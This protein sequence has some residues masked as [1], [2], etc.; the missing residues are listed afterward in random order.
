MQPVLNPP[1]AGDEW[2]LNDEDNTGMNP[3]AAGSKRPRNNEERLLTS[4]PNAGRKCPKQGAL[5][6][7]NSS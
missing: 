2:R 6:G 7:M 4:P 3:P 5:P 1:A